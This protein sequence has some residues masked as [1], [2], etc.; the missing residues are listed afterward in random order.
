MDFA[1]WNPYTFQYA[2]RVILT[3]C[4][5]MAVL[6]LA[7]WRFVPARYQLRAI[8]G[9]L[10]LFA[11]FTTVSATILGRPET[12]EP[13]IQMQL[14]WTIR[15]AITTRQGLYWYYIIGNIFLF[16]PFGA[17]L[18]VAWPWFAKWW[19]VLLAGA[20]VSAVV[21]VYQYFAQIGLCELD[22]VL[23]NAMGAFYG[24]QLYSIVWNVHLRRNWR[25]LIFSI[26]LVV[27]TITGFVLLLRWNRPDWTGI[28]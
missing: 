26:L 2:D 11:M 18:P 13:K 14:F 7:I 10:F 19:K 20:A 27:G 24:F 15:K 5:T 9:L 21:E 25:K 23:H 16:V 8:G 22:D 3:F 12:T 4:V 17:L 1:I 28:F 6:F